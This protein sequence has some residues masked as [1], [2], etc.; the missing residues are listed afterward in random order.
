MPP[1]HD[2]ALSP[3]EQAQ[4]GVHIWHNAFCAALLDMDAVQRKALLAR[5]ERLGRTIEQGKDT[6]SRVNTRAAR[7]HALHL[8]RQAVTEAE[9]RTPPLR[10]PSW[11]RDI[12]DC[13]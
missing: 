6:P 5:L 1:S 8:I 7:N 11:C 10:V 4:L 2:A 12:P 3:A 13:D 9:N